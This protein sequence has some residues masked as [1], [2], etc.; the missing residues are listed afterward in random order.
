MSASSQRSIAYLVL[1]RGLVALVLAAIASG[2]YQQPSTAQ[3]QSDCKSRQT[4]TVTGIVTSKGTLLDRKQ[5]MAI[6]VKD[7][8]PCHPGQIHANV[9][10]W[11]EKCVRNARLTATGK[12]EFDEDGG[13]ALI[14]SQVKC[15]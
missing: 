10:P 1:G 12:M 5:V 11:S 3:S 8:R 7:A 4:I 2:L 9:G 13:D 14:A 15:E 6:H